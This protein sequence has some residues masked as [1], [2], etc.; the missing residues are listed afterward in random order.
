LRAAPSGVRKLLKR[1]KGL[2]RIEHLYETHN[3]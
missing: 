1:L 3:S 2:Q